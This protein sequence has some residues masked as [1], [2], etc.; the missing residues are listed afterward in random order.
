MEF[1]IKGR[2]TDKVKIVIKESRQY[3]RSSEK[4]EN[5]KFNTVKTQEV[6]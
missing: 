1:K 2:N 3:L 5:F 4:K 6:S